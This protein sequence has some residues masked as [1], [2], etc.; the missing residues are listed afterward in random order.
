MSVKY[1]KTIAD[2]RID[3]ETW[4]KETKTM[5]NINLTYVPK[6]CSPRHA[7]AIIIPYRDREKQL[8]ML[9]SYLPPILERQQLAYHI[10]V[11]EQVQSCF[12]NSVI[13]KHQR[14]IIH[15]LEFKVH[16]SS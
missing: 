2:G 10:F 12:Y 11:V 15:F 4:L 14:Q 1:I 16:F 7:V 8:S 9:L 5:P 13:I 6:D 3:V